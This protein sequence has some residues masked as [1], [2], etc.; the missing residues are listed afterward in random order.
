MATAVIQ[1]I[2]LVHAIEQ[3]DTGVTVLLANL[4]D[5]GSVVIKTETMCDVVGLT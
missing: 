3:L 1:C 5:L 2:C 4:H